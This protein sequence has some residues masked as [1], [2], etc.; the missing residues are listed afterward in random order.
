MLVYIALDLSTACAVDWQTY[1]DTKLTACR[2]VR[3]ICSSFNLVDEL[4][5]VLAS[6]TMEA[7]HMQ[8]VKARAEANSTIKELTD[9]VDRVSK[10]EPEAKR[11]GGPKQLAVLTYHSHHQLLLSYKSAYACWDYVC[12]V[13]MI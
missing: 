12:F 9:F 6:L 4:N 5:T 13:L 3:D 1:F 10:E 7:K 11:R 8:S 2:G